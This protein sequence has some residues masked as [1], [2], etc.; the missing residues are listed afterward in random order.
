M[1]Q[2]AEVAEVEETDDLDAQLEAAW[3][4]QQEASNEEPEATEAEEAPEAPEADNPD[5]EPEAEE[6]EQIEPHQHWSNEDK[7]AFKT[8]SRPQQD[9]WVDR[10][11]R[12][13]HQYDNTARELNSTKQA[14]GEF[15]NMISPLVE[16]WERHGFSPTQGLTRMVALERDLRND[17]QA[18]LLRLAKESGVD[19]EKV[20]AEQPYV[21]PQTRQLQ[22]QLR[23][24]TEWREN[25]ERQQEQTVQRQQQQVQQQALTQLENFAS[26]TDES[27]NLKYPYVQDK[28]V[29][30]MMGESI[31]G[32]QAQNLPDAYEQ[33]VNSLRSHPLFQ[34][35]AQQLSSDT[36]AKV[37]KARGAS[38]VVRGDT[39]TAENYDEDAAILKMLED[40]GLE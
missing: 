35:Q 2:Q 1:V 8:L 13:S 4:A 10:E 39:A 22:E 32:G 21:D 40:A 36:Q 18:A 27:G 7:E 6:L 25:F 9:A 29:M 5:E 12:Y 38:K 3:D 31:R 20:H 14:V 37:K 11:R 28:T 34:E 23:K 24:E 16:G 33:A 26:A 17:P 30:E 19:L 15:H